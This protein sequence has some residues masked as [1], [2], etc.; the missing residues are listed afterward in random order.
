MAPVDQESLDG[1]VKFDYGHLVIQGPQV[2]MVGR[3]TC[4]K[5]NIQSLKHL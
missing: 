5:R 4:S 1:S 3:Q 2:T